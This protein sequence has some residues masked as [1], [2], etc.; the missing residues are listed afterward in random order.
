MSWSNEYAKGAVAPAVLAR[1]PMGA[2]CIYQ[3]NDKDSCR[4]IQGLIH[5]NLKRCGTKFKSQLLYAFN[6]A[7][8]PLYLV[9]VEV[10]QQ[11]RPL[12]RSKGNENPGN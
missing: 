5:S 2:I 10:L 3:A 12:K 11:G 9:H 8:D 7:G 6:M 1:M 4:K